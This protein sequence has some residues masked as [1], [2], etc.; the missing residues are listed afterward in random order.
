MNKIEFE[1]INV[2]FYDNFMWDSCKMNI[3]LYQNMC[4]INSNYTLYISGITLPPS[5]TIKDYLIWKQDELLD[6]LCNFK[7][8]HKFDS[9]KEEKKWY[10]EYRAI[11]KGCLDAAKNKLKQQEK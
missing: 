10:A 8:P 9:K 11:L 1:Q 5:K 4:I 3:Y 6:M 7:N 2:E